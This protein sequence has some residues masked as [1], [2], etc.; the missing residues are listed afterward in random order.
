MGAPGELKRVRVQRKRPTRAVF[1]K[2]LGSQPGQSVPGR[3][4]LS[5]ELV[6][7]REFGEQS[8][9]DGVLF[10]RRKGRDRVERLPK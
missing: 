2:R 7:V 10:L 9:R 4:Q 6:F 5:I 3:K 1:G 8:R